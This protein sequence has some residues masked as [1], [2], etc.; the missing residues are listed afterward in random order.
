MSEER[1]DL[2]GQVEEYLKQSSQVKIGHVENP[3]R[4]AKLVGVDPEDFAVQLRQGFSSA[5]T[6][7]YADSIETVDLINPTF[8]SDKYLRRHIYLKWDG[9][10][11]NKEHEMVSD[12]EVTPVEKVYPYQLA[13][14]ISAYSANLEKL[15]S[16]PDLFESRPEWPDRASALMINRLNHERTSMDLMVC[17][18]SDRSVSISHSHGWF[19]ELAKY[20]SVGLINDPDCAVY[21]IDIIGSETEHRNTF[22]KDIYSIRNILM[23]GELDIESTERAREQFIAK[24]PGKLISSP[25][26]LLLI[27][28]YFLSAIAAF[29]PEIEAGVKRLFNAQE[30]FGY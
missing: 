19:K 26:E 2:I 3:Y 12:D 4:R 28:P 7:D 9:K 21:G 11:P 22:F 17:N 5:L 30:Q 20:E 27:S 15:K 8:T 13:L 25:D 23:F 29:T 24:N 6:S 1:D 10:I 18:P 16:N 14:S